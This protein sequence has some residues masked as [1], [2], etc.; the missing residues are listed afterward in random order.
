VV[1]DRGAASTISVTKARPSAAKVS[2]V[3][4]AGADAVDEAEVV[5]A[6]EIATKF[7][8]RINE[9]NRIGAIANETS[10][11]VTTVRAEIVTEKN[12]RKNGARLNRP[13]SK[14]KRLTNESSKWSKRPLAKSGRRRRRLFL[15]SPGNHP[16][17]APASAYGTRSSVRRPS[18]LQN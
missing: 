7:K 3:E 14:R 13:F 16:S 1:A 17:R 8:I 18:R 11:I 4:A 2:A 10:E 5:E 9:N 15:L 6:H 12:V